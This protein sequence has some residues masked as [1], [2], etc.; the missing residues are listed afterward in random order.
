VKSKSIVGFFFS[1][2]ILLS[3]GYSGMSASPIRAAIKVQ[4]RDLANQSSKVL[5]SRS[6]K[7]A[8]NLEE[9]LIEEEDDEILPLKKENGSD[10]LLTFHNAVPTFHPTYRTGTVE[11][12]SSAHFSTDKAFVRLCVFRI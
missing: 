4:P 1:F 5:T 11:P 12:I 2:L 7:E 9:T 6:D 8:Y 10:L 3:S